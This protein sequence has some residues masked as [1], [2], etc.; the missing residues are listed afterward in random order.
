VRRVD[1]ALR[2]AAR[3]DAGPVVHPADGRSR[4]PRRAALTGATAALATIATALALPAGTAAAATSTTTATTRTTTASAAARGATPGSWIRRSTRWSVPRSTAAR[5]GTKKVTQGAVQAA[6]APVPIPADLTAYVRDDR[7]DLQWSLRALHVPQAWSASRGAGVVVATIDTGADTTAPDLAGQLLPGAYLTPAGAIA[8]GNQPD[9]L[10]HGTH[11]AGIIAGND[12]GHGVTGVAPDA[13][14][15]PVDVDST[16]D[17]LT[18][19]QV[20][21]AIAWATTHGA[22]VINLSLGFEDVATGAADVKAV[23]QAVSAAVAKNVVVV[24]ASGNDGDSS[25]EGKAPATCPGAISVAALDNDLRPTPWSSFDGSVTV[26][27][28]G[29]SIWSTVAPVTSPLRYSAESGT[30]MAAP[31]VSG[32]AALLLAQHPDWTPAQVTARLV[33][34]A[35]DVAPAGRDPRTG[36]GTVDPAAALGVSTAPPEAVPVLASQADP[37]A[38]KVDANGAGVYDR[39]ELHWVPD[40]NFP[41]TG[42]RVTRWTTAGTTETSFDAGTVRAL[43]P[44]GPA[45]YQVTATS[46]DGDVR[47]APV[48]FPLAG[49]D[50]TPLYPV[51]GLKAAWTSSGAVTLRWSN[52]ARNRGLADQYAVLVNGEFALTKE[53]VTV[54]TTVTI[55]AKSLPGGD[56][57][58]SVIVG[59]SRS[60]DIEETRVGLNARVPFSGTAVGAGKGRYRV[61]LALAPSRRPACGRAACT[62][63]TVTVTVG[64]H[65][66][67]TRLDSTG[68]AVVVV[69]AAAKKGRITV[70]VTMSGRARL[71]DRA[72]AVPVG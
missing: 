29:A 68:H 63:A 19:K 48:W 6:A 20:G 66:W 38:T 34:T 35:A 37:Y 17:V 28:P 60:N 67:S 70:G 3:P 59:S 71:T 46:P 65:A 36:A 7:R 26:A 47:S 43:F 4:G 1:Q 9:K 72:L 10:G 16:D 50:F 53:N 24:A 69:A 51:T 21:T 58:I 57:D 54:P 40:P 52:P 11:V 25:N 22:K 55:P 8:V 33:A 42:Y 27:A 44:A 56:L 5:P 13:K 45:G 41:A 14:V 64:G 39:T 49:Q 62:G 15:L 32:V 61:D 31:F 2:P 18:G 12:D 23:C 30:S